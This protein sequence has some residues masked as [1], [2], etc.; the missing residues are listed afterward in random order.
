MSHEKIARWCASLAEV[1]RRL[2]AATRSDPSVLARRAPSVSAWSIGEH[3]QHI[4]RVNAKTLHQ[5]NKILDGEGD[6]ITV[7]TGSPTL[8]AKVTA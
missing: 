5:L 3:I 1:H 2:R 6:D 4:A 8:V 7:R